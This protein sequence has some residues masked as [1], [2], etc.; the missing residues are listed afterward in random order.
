MTACAKLR[1]NQAR[2]IPSLKH[3]FGGSLCGTSLLQ[4]IRQPSAARHE[5]DLHVVTTACLRGSGQ[6]DSL[7]PQAPSIDTGSSAIPEQKPN[8]APDLS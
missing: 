8:M 5:L 1:Q 2:Q 3:F 6:S 4:D 7:P